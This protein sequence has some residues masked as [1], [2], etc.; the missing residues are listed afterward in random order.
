MVLTRL[1]RTPTTIN[2][3]VTP[4][5]QATMLALLGNPRSQYDDVCREVT[6]TTLKALM[7]L[8]SVGPF[9]VQGLTPAVE[10][11][12]GNSEDV[13]VLQPDFY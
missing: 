9:R 12:K 1:I 7:T 4:A 11:L 10:S 8:S 5:R 6:N 2:V 13:P 3:G